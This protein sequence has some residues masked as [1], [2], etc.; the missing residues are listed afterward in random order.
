MPKQ[1]DHRERREMIAR[2]LW[3]VVEQRGVTHLTVREVAREAGMSH[4]Q[5]QHYFASREAMLSFAM[6]FASEQTSLRVGQGLQQLGDRPHPRDVLRVMLTEMLPL[7]ADARATSRMSAAFVLEAL[8]NENFHARARDGMTQGRSLVEQ[9]IRQA[10][11]DGHIA[12]GRDPAAEAHLLL[13]LTGFTTLLE[14]GVIE[15]QEALAAIDHHLDR[16][17]L[18][19]PED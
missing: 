1:V 17:F 9:L 12:P 2:A 15:P 19:T 3:R 14:L 5:L 18:R 11:T 10:I 16:L 8:H 6:D 13:A 7:H 4:G